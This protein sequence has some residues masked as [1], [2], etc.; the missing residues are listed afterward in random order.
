MIVTEKD[1]RNLAS[2]VNRFTAKIISLRD[3]YTLVEN[4]HIDINISI[5][6]PACLVFTSGTTGKP[7][8]IVYSH[9]TI[10]SRV[11]RITT[12]FNI[13]ND[14]NISLLPSLGVNAG[15]RD[16]FSALLNGATLNIFDI[17]NQGTHRVPQWIEKQKN[18]VDF[19]SS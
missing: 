1:Y 4:N 19:T 8:G 9:S 16:I 5:N 12:D 11:E 14:D 7:N 13:N 10:L 17:V 3:F 2:K 6:D 18:M 15:L